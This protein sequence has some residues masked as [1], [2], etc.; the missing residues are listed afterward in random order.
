MN[1]KEY[2][3]WKKCQQ[4]PVSKPRLKTA[5]SMQQEIFAAETQLAALKFVNEVVNKLFELASDQKILSKRWILVRIKSYVV[6]IATA[7]AD[8]DIMADEDIID[9][10]LP[11]DATELFIWTVEAFLKDFLN[12]EGFSSIGDEAPSLNGLKILSDPDDW[13]AME[14]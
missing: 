10:P 3:Q 4:K 2:I 1:S 8:F 6:E 12:A 9:I 5:V 7:V 13:F 11:N 14:I